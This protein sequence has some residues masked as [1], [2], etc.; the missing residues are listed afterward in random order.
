M[1]NNGHTVK[2]NILAL[3]LCIGQVSLAIYF[4]SATGLITGG[5]AGLTLFITKFVDFSFGQVFFVIN[6]PFYIFALI[7]MGWRFTLTTFVAIVIMSVTVDYLPLVVS[8]QAMHP[9][10]AAVIGGM[11]IGVG[12]L[13]MFRHKMSFGGF[14]ILALYLQDKMGI[15]AGKVQMGLDC[16]IVI[17]SLF[18]ID[19]TLIALSVTAAVIT[20]LVLVFNHVPGRYQPTLT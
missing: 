19:W 17:L 20:N 1:W 5:T 3:M 4:Y 7:S 11:L 16:T 2:E 10:Y 8:I 14:N 12:T 9:A 15:S 18:F 13:G 6:L